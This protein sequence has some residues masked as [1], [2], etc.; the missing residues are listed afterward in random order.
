MTKQEKTRY[1]EIYLPLEDPFSSYYFD[2][3]EKASVISSLSLVNIFIGTNNSGKSRLLRSIFSLKN[4]N[5]NCTNNYNVHQFYELINDA[6]IE[7]KQAFPHSGTMNLPPENIDRN[8][9]DDLINSEKDCMLSPDL[10]RIYKQ[11]DQKLKMMGSFQISATLSDEYKRVANNVHQVGKKYS[12]LSKKI[13]FDITLGEEKRYYI[14]ILRG[15]RPL[16]ENDQHINLYKDRTLKD[17]FQAPNPPLPYKNLLDEEKMI[18]FTGLELY[19]TLKEKLLG[20]PE[21]RDLVKKFEN[22]LSTKFFNSKPVILIPKEKGDDPRVVHIKIGNDKQRPIYELG[23]GLQNLIICTFNIFTEKDRCLF[24]IEEPDMLMHPSLQRSFLEILSDFDQHQYFITSHSNHFLDM[25]LDFANISVFHFSKIEDENKIEAE[26]PSF[27]VEV[28]SEQ[29][30]RILM[31]LGVQNSSVFLS[32]STI[33]VEGI[34]DRLYLRAY[35]KK[36]IQELKN[37]KPEEAVSISNFREDYHYSFVEY[38]GSNLTHWSFDPDEE[39][40]K[41][42]KSSYVC[43][44]SF[45][46]ADGDV[47]TKGD[48]VDIYKEMLGDDK[49]FPLDVKEIENLIPLEVLKKLVEANFN[50]YGGDINSIKYEDYAEKGIEVGLGNYLEEFL[51]LKPLKTPKKSKKSQ[52]NTEKPENEVIVVYKT[53]SGTIK[54]K[55]NF[56]EKAI[57][58]MEDPSFSWELNKKLKKLCKAI[59]EHIKSQ[60]ITK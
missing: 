15:M 40:I 12:K 56:C 55:I 57:K 43:A 50:R 46:I 17:Y 1:S 36:Y 38:Q 8:Y 23:D 30:R 21:D 60:N 37:S 4:F 53:D 48:R 13:P 19:Q 26:K 28:A 7:L 33:W 2:T 3:P 6:D 34:T 51:L 59:F 49:F 35:M 10:L 5:Y 16:D 27:K 31:D 32:N 47:A 29:H 24:F 39:D 58:I 41:K 20:E 22:F 42:I 52:S 25:T 14:P 54:S 18:V 11:M 9:L 45:L 44:N